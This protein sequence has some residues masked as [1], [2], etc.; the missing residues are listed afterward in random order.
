M[1]GYFGIAIILIALGIFAA[2]ILGGFATLIWSKRCHPKNPSFRRPKS[3]FQIG[4]FPRLTHSESD[5]E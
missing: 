5:A 2:L 1:N 4:F 3:V